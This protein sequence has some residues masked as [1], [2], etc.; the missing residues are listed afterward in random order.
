[1]KCHALCWRLILGLGVGAVSVPATAEHVSSSHLH[2]KH[3]LQSWG[4]TPDGRGLL[5]TALAEIGDAKQHTETGLPR[6]S[7]PTGTAYSVERIERE[8]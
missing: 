5:P 1:M 6:D 8:A 4:G 3:V 7:T 2:M